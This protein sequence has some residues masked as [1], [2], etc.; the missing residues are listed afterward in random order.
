[1]AKKKKKAAKERQYIYNVKRSNKL[2]T[3]IAAQNQYADSLLSLSGVITGWA[4]SDQEEPKFSK[5]KLVIRAY[6]AGP[7]SLKLYS[8]VNLTG[9]TLVAGASLNQTDLAI[10]NSRYGLKPFDVQPMTPLLVAKCVG[11]NLWTVQTT[12]DLR[13]MVNNYLLRNQQETDSHADWNLLAITSQEDLT[14]VTICPFTEAEYE[15]RPRKAQLIK[16]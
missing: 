11:A 3:T 13:D 9:G 14:T 16:L 1:M 6:S 4:V 2:F 7:F 12:L 5:F 10:W 8:G 15:L